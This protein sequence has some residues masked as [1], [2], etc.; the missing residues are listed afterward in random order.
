MNHYTE[1]KLRKGFRQKFG[2]FYINN[3]YSPKV[4]DLENV[5]LDIVASGDIEDY[6]L[7][8]FSEY[9]KELV[10]RITPLKKIER[11]GI[12]SRT[13]WV[14]TEEEESYNHALKD[15]IQII[16]EENYE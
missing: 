14:L 12:S 1:D 6:W 10:D 7:S 9:K 5:P 13:Q 2:R 4:I 3:A 16:H 8:K 11:P 15:I